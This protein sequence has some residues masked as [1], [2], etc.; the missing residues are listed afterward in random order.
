[1]YELALIELA[2][3]GVSALAF[4]C[5]GFGGSM[6]PDY[7]MNAMAV[8][9][10]LSS[11]LANLTD[12][13]VVLVGGHLSAEF[14]LYWALQS[15]D[16]VSGVVLDGVYALSEEEFQPLLE[17]YAGLSPRFNEQGTHETFLW[18]ATCAVMKEW[19][20]YLELSPDTM[21][22]IYDNMSDYL[23]M[24]YPA[25]RDWMEGDK[26]A[27]GLAVL[28][29][30]RAVRQPMLILSAEDDPLRCAFERTISACANPPRSHKFSGVHPLATTGSASTYA[31]VLDLFVR[32]L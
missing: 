1:M 14:A 7:F 22:A 13:K 4:D 15:P 26:S 11:G 20:P 10:C 16:Q 32:S 9:D 25:I 21:E 2:S 24:G 28:E 5:P 18:R 31:E 23:A 19:N 8:A 27:P 3:R 6:R 29:L 12:R 30:V 17:P